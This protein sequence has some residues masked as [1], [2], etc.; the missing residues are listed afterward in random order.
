RLIEPASCGNCLA[1]TLGFAS[2]REA[3]CWAT[4]RWAEAER[5]AASRQAPAAIAG[6]TPGMRAT[7][8]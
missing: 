7:M 3:R 5:L 6:A 4:Q 8:T 1:T 2:A